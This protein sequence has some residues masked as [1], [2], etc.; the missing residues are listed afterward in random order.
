M[1][2][3]VLEYSNH[4]IELKD[5]RVI[6]DTAKKDKKVKVVNVKEKQKGK[7]VFCLRNRKR[8]HSSLN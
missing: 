7:F 3:I 2:Y 1:N 4:I 5:G 6:S 8:C